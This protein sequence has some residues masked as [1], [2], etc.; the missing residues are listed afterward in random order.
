MRATRINGDRIV[1]RIGDVVVRRIDRSRRVDEDGGLAEAGVR[2]SNDRS[3]RRIARVGL[4]VHPDL[5]TSVGDVVH[6]HVDLWGRAYA[7]HL[8]DARYRMACVDSCV[9]VRWCA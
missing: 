8:S 4:V 3:R 1:R 6:T 5:R 7:G 9:W 2:S